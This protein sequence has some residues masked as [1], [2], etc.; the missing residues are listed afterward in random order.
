MLACLCVALIAGCTTAPSGDQVY[1]ASYVGDRDSVALGDV[2]VTVPLK[3]ADAPYANLHIVLSAI[4]NP[5]KT[6]FSEVRKVNDLVVRLSPRICSAVVARI[7]G[8]GVISASDLGALRKEITAEANRVFGEAF[9]KW[10][11]A[12][13]YSVEIVV[14][15]LYLTKDTV[16]REAGTG[17]RFW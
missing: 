16:G 9:A 7:L 5:K 14:T 11:D 6:S 3:D 1:S 12:G 15:S 8:H 17:R 2:V 13:D 4:I 10:V